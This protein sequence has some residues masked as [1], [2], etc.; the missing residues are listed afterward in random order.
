MRKQLST[1]I[2]L[3]CMAAVLPCAARAKK[4]AKSKKSHKTSS[5]HHKKSEP[6]TVVR[7]VTYDQ[8][9]GTDSVSANN[10][11]NFAQNLIGIRYRS[12]T[13]DPDRGFDCSGFVSYVFK[14]FNFNVP[15]SSGEFID[16]GE[17]VTYDDAKPGD[18]VIFTS[19]TNSHRIGHVGIVYSNN[20]G[21][22]K[23]IHSTSG[24]EHGVT[25]T[26]MDDT[27]KMRFVQVVRLLKRNDVML[28]SR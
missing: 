27:Y 11:I 9:F 14:N 6:E 10:I 28:A 24:K 20:G 2:I 15:R 12:A 18:I 3:L 26:T 4:P 21:E 1:L 7:H 5:R 17:K 16:V 22:F 8:T 13:S 19:P 23:F 25:I